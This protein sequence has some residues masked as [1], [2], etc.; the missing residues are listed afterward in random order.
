M[1]LITVFL[2]MLALLIMIGAGALLARQ[3]ILD[4][5]TSARLS[6]MILVLFNP[7]LSLSS[8]IDAA[9]QIPLSRLGLVALIAAGMYFV[10]LAAGRLLAP[11]F[12][13]DIVQ[14]R[15]YQMMF[16]F[17]N[18]GFIGIPVVSC[19][20]GTDYVIYVTEFSLMFNVFFYTYGMAL[21]DGSFSLSSLKSMVNPA[22]GIVLLSILVVALNLHFPSFIN[23]A[24]SY[25]GG[26]ASPMALI[27]VGYTIAHSDLKRIFA[28]PRLYLFA[29]L[30]LLA[31]PLLLLP[32]LR[33]LP[34][35]E[36][37]VA[38]CMI[39][40]GMPV[41]NM[42]LILGTQKGLDCTACSAGIIMTT[43]FC[44]VTVP[45]LMAAV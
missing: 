27:T 21:M 25:L 7:L 39:M 40:F 33:L 41:G 38:F 16:G 32:V 26:V 5:H 1:T 12:D 42:P 13:R 37:M 2:Q 4:D 18:V 6:T 17:P 9:G 35:E 11:F 44:V 3:E 34:L 43:L 19:I 45:I 28:S 8:A 14:R 30:K 10:F 22:N 20:L 23:T 36:N 15:M 29:A 24:V 31:M